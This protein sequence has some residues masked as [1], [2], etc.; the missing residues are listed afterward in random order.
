M[1]HVDIFVC[2]DKKLLISVKKFLI[3]P[4]GGACTPWI[5]VCDGRRLII[6]V[7]G[8][9]LQSSRL[10]QLCV[11]VIWRTSAVTGSPNLAS[12][13]DFK[14]CTIW[15]WMYKEI[16]EMQ[17]SFCKEAK[18]ILIFKSFQ[19]YHFPPPV[20]VQYT[21][22]ASSSFHTSFVT[23]ESKLRIYYHDFITKYNLDSI[24]INCSHWWSLQI[25]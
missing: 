17:K 12:L 21:L 22:T 2:W 15:T 20:T 6:L 13:H 4:L 10:S 8:E 25:T 7:L 11:S 5:I 16:G 19:I 9:Q 14:S 18:E 1:H 23:N 24:W 3:L